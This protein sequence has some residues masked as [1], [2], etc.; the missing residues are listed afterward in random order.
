[1]APL[2]EWVDPELTLQ[3]EGAVADLG[4]T[5]AVE[6]G[7]LGVALVDLSADDYW[8]AAMLNADQMFYA[9]SLP[10]VAVM[11]AVFEQAE[12]GVLVIDDEVRGQL[13][14]MIKRS[15]NPDTTAL[16]HRVGKPIIADILESP[17][18][19]LY[20]RAGRGGIWVGKDYAKEGLWQRDPLSNF[21][22]A[23]TPMQVARF[24]TLLHGGHLVSPEASLEMKRLLADS[25]IQHKFVKGLK[26]ANPDAVV[27]R[28]SGTWRE[29]HSDGA[30]VEDGD[31]VYVAVGL[32]TD[33]KGGQWLERLIVA[34][35][36]L[37]E[38]RAKL[39]GTPLPRPLQ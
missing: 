37:I 15:S 17:R 8:P 1:M 38:A 24:L 11:L 4:L 22:H 34:L 21:S 13:E 3:L 26:R 39:R 36:G 20:D 19:R 16:I 5:A 12:A 31:V 9:A 27:H 30:L 32:S 7:R 6:S 25:R 28:K 18:Y 10:K 33:P 2:W 35:D 29:H 23:A 14:R